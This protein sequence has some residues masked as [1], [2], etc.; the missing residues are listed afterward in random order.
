VWYRSRGKTYD[1]T[2]HTGFDQ[3]FIN[4]REI[5]ANI[6]RIVDEIFNNFLRRQ[7]RREPFFAEYCDGRIAQCPGLK[8]WGS[9][10]LALRGYTPI[11][12]LHYYYPKDLQIFQ[13]NTFI[14]DEAKQTFPG[15]SLKEG[16]TGENVRKMQM[17]LNRISGNWYIQPIP[18]PNGVFGPET[19][20]TVKEFQRI[21]NLIPDGIIGRTTWYDITRIYVAAKKLAELTSEGERISV[22]AAP[23]TVTVRLNDRGEY[24]VELQFI[25][26]LISGFFPTIPL[27]IQDGV[28]KENTRQAVLAFQRQ[29]GMTAD[30]VVGPGTWQKLYEVYHSVRK[31]VPL[32]PSPGIPA[33]PGV[34]L[35]EGSESNDVRIMQNNL[36]DIAAIHPSIPRVVADGKFGPATRSAVMAFQRLFGLTAD[37]VIGSNTWYRIID[38]RNSLPSTPPSTGLPPYPGTALRFGSR[39][40][41]VTTVQN[42][43]N[44]V[45][46]VFPAIPALTADGSFGPATQTAVTAFQRIFGLTADGVVGPNTWN[47]IMSVSQNLS[48]LTAPA[49]PGT[50]RVGS[51]GA[52]VTAAQRYLNGIRGRYPSIQTL[53]TDGSF[54]PVTQSAVMTF[55]RLLGLNPDGVVGPL[56]W[57]ML[58][59]MYNSIN[60]GTASAAAFVGDADYETETASHKPAG[61]NSPMQMLLM[62]QL[63]RSRMW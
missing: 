20:R 50:M 56:T 22:G 41:D 30:G 53:V 55:Q 31:D 57:N 62:M 46:R 32:P 29:Y 1:I 3:Y 27:V 10:D 12:I 25:L 24:V 47:K 34:P 36:N 9:Q 33:Y 48:G 28:F 6:G 16:S 26:A 58:V 37:G 61:Q 15:S 60:M 23:P 14:T 17:Y 54:G 40:N 59:S 42:R 13:T 4:G 44:T 7:G 52:G 43:L 5:Y 49:F 21:F 63:L 18:N 8:Q 51:R 11:Q 38:I 19:T 35:R 45:R 39:G 2:N